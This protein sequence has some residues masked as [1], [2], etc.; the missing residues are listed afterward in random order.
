MAEKPPLEQ[1]LT[2]ARAEHV[3][4]KAKGLGLRR[5]QGRSPDRPA[6]FTD[7]VERDLPGPYADAIRA[8]VDAVVHR[9][10]VMLS[11]VDTPEGARLVAYVVVSTGP[12]L[13][14]HLDI[15]IGWSDGSGDDTSVLATTRLRGVG[16]TIWRWGMADPDTRST[17]GDVLDDAEQVLRGEPLK[18][19]SDL[20]PQYWGV[21]GIVITILVIVVS[22]YLSNAS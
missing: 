7:R 15:D 1:I 3:L 20:S 19:A 22:I 21:I 18:R 14:G 4:Q 2:P 6:E 8:L 5:G 9:G 11:M 16:S 12:H 13:D 17:I 10:H